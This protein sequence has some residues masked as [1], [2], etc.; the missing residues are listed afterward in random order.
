MNAFQAT[1]DDVASAER[2]TGDAAAQQARQDTLTRVQ[3]DLDDISREVSELESF[4]RINYTGALKAAKKHDRRRGTNYKVRP[5]VQVRLA[6]LPFNT[7]DYS[8][9]LYRLSGMYAFIRQRLADTTGRTVSSPDPQET[10]GHSV[11]HKFFIHPDNLLEVKTIVL[12]HLPVLLY[13]PSSVKD[14][15]QHQR[16]PTITALYFDNSDFALYT[17]KLD[18][19]KG[20]SSLRIR[21]YD[22]LVENP[23][24]TLEQKTLREGDDS[25][26]INVGIK[27]KYVMPFLKGQ[28][29]MEKTIQKLRGQKGGVTPEVEQVERN[30]N[31]LQAFVQEN[32]LEPMLRVNY[33][34][35]AFQIP[36]EDRIRV[37]I[38]TNLT[39]IREDC[40]DMARPCRDPNQWH[41]TAIDEAGLEFPFSSISKG[42]ISHFPYAVME[43][44]TLQGLKKRRVE[45]IEDL[46]TSHLVKEAPRFSK[47]LHG[48]AALFDDYVNFMP[49]WMSLTDTDIRRDPEEAFQE[50]QDKKAKQAADEFVV[51][52]LL[53]SAPKAKPQDFQPAMS[54]PIW[55]KGKTLVSQNG[56]GE[57]VQQAAAVGREQAEDGAGSKATVGDGPSK[58]ARLRDLFPPFSISKY[59]RAQRSTTQLPHGIKKPEYFLKDVGEVKVEPK[60]WLANQR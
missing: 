54:S 53:G 10:D 30:V 31:D 5:L 37:S 2:S 41:R 36:G 34:R 11:S 49:F 48:V 26:E 52:S 1:L 3:R 12:R 27:D 44:K 56:E 17:S 23:E 19:G 18:R 60:V 57:P 22:R 47:F 39:F 24:V 55:K 42:E 35:T 8:P 58:G 4:S 32:K 50:E 51:G 33:T 20:S 13:T 14:V 59:A 40:L 21:W 9:F 6:S 29:K 45:W 46:T 15:G 38:D 25:D 7:E 43:V 28:Y 16:D